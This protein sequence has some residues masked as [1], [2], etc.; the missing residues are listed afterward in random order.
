MDTLDFRYFLQNFKNQLDLYANVVTVKSVPGVKSQHKNIDFI[1]IRE[2]TGYNNLSF[3]YGKM[4]DNTLFITLIHISIYNLDEL[5]IA[6]QMV[7]NGL[8]L[9]S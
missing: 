7:L 6:K 2:Q 3:L 5:K 8:T 1:V 9:V 4:S